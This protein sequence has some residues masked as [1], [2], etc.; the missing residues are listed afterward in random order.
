MD[1][2]AFQR[3]G[4]YEHDDPESESRL[5]LLRLLTEDGSTIEEMQAAL[6]EGRLI[7]LAVD[8]VVRPPGD[9]MTFAEMCIQ[10]DLD[11]HATAAL[12]RAG[13]F[14]Q[15]DPL[16]RVFVE[17]DVRCFRFLSLMAAL[18]DG[19]PGL[20]ITRVAG[21][22][23]SA[24]AEAELAA[25]RSSFEG[26]LRAAGTN[27]YDQAQSFR[28]VAAMLPEVLH[29]LDVF[30]R[31]HLLAGMRAQVL[32]EGGRPNVE[33]AIGFADL[34]GYTARVEASDAPELAAIVDRFG[35]I[36]REVITQSGGRLVKL[37][38][39]E[40]MFQAPTP[41]SGCE[42]A[43]ALVDAFSADPSLPEV[44]VGLGFGRVLAFEGDYYGRVVNEAARL[45]K[46]AEPGCVLATTSVRHGAAGFTFEAGGVR[47][48]KGIGALETHRLTGHGGPHH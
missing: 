11:E 9:R 43:L 28:A 19:D 38:G 8:A 30:H 27:E 7:G 39:D 32:W 14:A 36:A 4:L 20:Q 18:G 21:A 44:R 37:I 40:V 5:A 48:V 17:A 34:V 23:M 15:P 2:E 25:V 12:L 46:E 29:V 16:D 31:R 35:R 13:G 33:G 26:P 6:A 10:A 47:D 41:H 24:L 22:A 42:I 45:V 3:A 1:V